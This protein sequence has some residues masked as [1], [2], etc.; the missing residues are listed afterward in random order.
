MYL[1]LFITPVLPFVILKSQRDAR[2]SRRTSLL[3]T[4]FIAVLL[5]GGLIWVGK[6]MP[7][8][9][10]ILDKGGI[11]PYPMIRSE[12]L[13]APRLFWVAVTGLSLVGSAGMLKGLFSAGVALYSRLRKRSARY[14]P[15]N[16]ALLFSVIV[17]SFAPLP[18][19]GLGDSG[20]YDR[21]VLI[22]VPIII[23]LLA[24]I[25]DKR[26]I[27]ISS[28]PAL[29]GL[30]LL[31]LFSVFSIAGTH[32]YLALNRTR[33]KALQDLMRERNIPA[34][35]IYAGLDFGGWYFYNQYQRT[36][37]EHGSGWR[38]TTTLFRLASRTIMRLI[39]DILFRGGY[40]GDKAQE[41]LLF[42]DESQGNRG[43]NSGKRVSAGIA[44]A[45]P[46][47]RQRSGTVRPGA[48]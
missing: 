11:G 2:L 22:F 1:G 20:F 28:L 21:Y 4:A 26:P 13:L 44:T 12:I 41:K 37:Q 8:W 43:G 48:H 36:G 19:L 38:K 17:V 34:S 24:S 35:H 9:R 15:W 46:P 16:L 27:S 45:R 10:N 30:G 6:L 31:T 7:L 29:A 25:G 33:W 18:L 5:V 47:L 3:V 14:H 32:D 23:A 40:R 39:D 42:S